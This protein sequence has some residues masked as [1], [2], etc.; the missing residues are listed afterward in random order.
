MYSAL[1]LT[2]WP[3]IADRYSLFG[4]AAGLILTVDLLIK[5]RYEEGLLKRHFSEYAAYMKVTKRL[6]PFVL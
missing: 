4:L 5:I 3:L 1:L 6:I 2:F